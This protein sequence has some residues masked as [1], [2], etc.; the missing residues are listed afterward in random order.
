MRYAT[1]ELIIQPLFYIIG[2][3][4]PHT[5]NRVTMD[6][7]TFLLCNFQQSHWEGLNNTTMKKAIALL[8]FFMAVSQFC[9]AQDVI[10][11]RDAKRIEA[12]V[13]EISDTEI[14]Y[15]RQDNP[16]GPMFVIKTSQVASIMFANGE[17]QS[18]MHVESEQPQPQPQTS[19]S[20]NYDYTNAPVVVSKGRMARY[21]PGVQ[22]KYEGFKMTY[23][24]VELNKE[25]CEDFLKATCPD[26]YKHYNSAVWV[27]Y[28]ADAFLEVGGAFFIWGLIYGLAKE[29]DAYT[30]D[31]DIEANTTALMAG[32]L[33]CAVLSIPF[34]VWKVSLKT[35]SVNTFN[36]QCSHRPQ[37]SS[38]ASL[39]FSVSP[40]GAGLA[41]N[42]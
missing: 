39:S 42:F 3:P 41:L 26:A 7:S 2:R 4:S 8:L 24:G 23:N 32:G 37:S 19:T 12:S 30:S 18:F 22:M 15:K 9:T 1:V 11:T 29:P 14:R 27:G 16:D 33:A 34:Y 13:Q 5:E 38:V 6:G 40:T 28:V 20:S 21:T 10:I 36:A 31:A 25:A 35:K 17:V